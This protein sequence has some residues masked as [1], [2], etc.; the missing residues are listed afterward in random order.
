[1]VLNV[2][3]YKK[4]DKKRER[5]KDQGAAKEKSPFHQILEKEKE[6]APEHVGSF[7]EARA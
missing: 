3:S 5:P 7:F 1:M 6:K 4:W 2:D